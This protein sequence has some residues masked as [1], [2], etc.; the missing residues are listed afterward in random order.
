M[1]V[2]DD[3]FVLSNQIEAG[4]WIVIG[5]IFAAA[6]LRKS[7]LPQRQFAEKHRLKLETLRCWLYRRARPAPESR[8]LPVRVAEGTRAGIEIGLPSGVVV[9]LASGTP[10]E[11]VAALVRALG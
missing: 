3:L 1:P 7:G 10:A 5:L 8:L 6:A 4:F 11:E 2:S 9:R